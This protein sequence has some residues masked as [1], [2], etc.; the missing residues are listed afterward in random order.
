[1]H[2]NA[3]G[4]EQEHIMAS[5]AQ[6]HLQIVEIEA[7]GVYEIAALKPWQSSA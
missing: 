6:L 7:L 5:H 3:V 1:M 4:A 2:T